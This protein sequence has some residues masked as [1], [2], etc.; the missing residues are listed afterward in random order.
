MFWSE[1]DKQWHQ[2]NDVYLRNIL[3]KSRLWDFKEQVNIV[4]RR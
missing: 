2:Y 1:M 3:L 4:V